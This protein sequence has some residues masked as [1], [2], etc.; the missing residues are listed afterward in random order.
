MVS[1]SSKTGRLQAPRLSP[2]HLHELRDATDSSFLSGDTYDGERF[3]RPTLDGLDLTASDFIDCEFQGATFHQAQLRGV[4][5]RNCILADSF[6]PVFTAARSTWRDV[7]VTAPR[8]GSAELYDST[9]QSV[10][11]DGGKLDFLNLRTAKI[12]DLLIS[13]CIINELDLGGSTV[14]RMALKNCRIGTLDVSAAKCTDLDLRGSEFSA[15]HGIG[16]LAGAVID[17]Y[18]LGLLAPL[19]AGYLGI[20]VA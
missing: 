17:D 16:N 5:F 6:A 7:V 18:Q 19:L 13:D 8:W 3:D 4:R 1:K 9:W 20:S 15:I 12:S 11:I 2:V 14:S 10:R